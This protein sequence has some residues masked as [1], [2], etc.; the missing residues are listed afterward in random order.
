MVQGYK[1]E[2]QPVSL[3]SIM[4]V[5]HLVLEFRPEVCV[6]VWVWVWVWVWVCNYLLGV[7]YLCGEFG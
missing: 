4:T 6:C 1:K 2:G 7:V 3:C 5:T